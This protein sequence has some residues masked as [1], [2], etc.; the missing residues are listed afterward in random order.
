[1]VFI[2]ILEQLTAKGN[3]MRVQCVLYILTSLSVS[4]L[5]TKG[6]STP[7]VLT[8]ITE[9][10]E[11]EKNLND[12]A[13]YSNY[14]CIVFPRSSPFIIFSIDRFIMALFTFFNYFLYESD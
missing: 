3:H 11:G 6:T 9:L 8:P 7:L 5:F 4:D 10:V 14:T 2:G 13:W 1:M 12:I